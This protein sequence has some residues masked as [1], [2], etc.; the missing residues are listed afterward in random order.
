LRRRPISG[1]DLGDELVSPQYEGYSILNIPAS[2]CRL[3]GAPP[4]GAEPLAAEILA[5]FSGGLRQVV[6]VLMDALALHRLQRWVQAG[7]APIWGQLAQK[8]VLAPLTSITPSTTSAA[9]TSLWT[10]RSAAQHGIVGYEMWLKEYGV[11]A[12]AILHAPMS[13]KGDVGSLSKAGFTPDGF[14]PLPTLAPHLARHGI[15]TRALQHASIAKSG[16]SQMFFKRVDVHKFHTAADLWINMRLL[17]EANPLER[18]YTWVYWSQVDHFSHLYGPDDER[19]A[20]EFST[21]SSAFERYFLGEISP[22]ARQDTLLIL[23]A[24]HGAIATPH[25]PH[26]ELRNHPDLT[27]RL[28]ILPSG[29][30]R[31]A[32][33]F[34]RPGQREAVEEYLERAW[35]G[36]FAV[37]D[38]VQAVEAGLFG[39]GA[40]HPML[41][42][43]LGDAVVVARKDAYLWWAD[44][45]NH[46]LGRHGGLHSQEMLVPF[47]AVRL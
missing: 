27:A 8:G 14:M 6:L 35:P 40:P 33:F 47:L 16:L 43:R 3:L 17:L 28:H 9:L 4:I 24:D 10:G 29:E 13:F 1:I 36:Q 32:Y 19:P 37:V 34:I 26:Y 18:S 39:P 20:A 45:D 30:N 23:T 5:P 15:S 2:I 44:E 21:F 41:Y 42:D 22:R 25:N 31:L 38:P 11:V 12:N 46:L 7:A